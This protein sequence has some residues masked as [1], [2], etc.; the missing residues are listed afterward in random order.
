MFTSF[1]I[2]KMLKVLLKEFE[3]LSIVIVV[4][5]LDLISFKT[6]KQR[7]P[8]LV[9]TGIVRYNLKFE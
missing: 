4:R 1:A 7:S 5:K 8:S 6:E 3:S 9:V 2:F